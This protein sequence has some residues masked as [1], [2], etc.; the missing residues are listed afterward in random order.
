M[1]WLLRR[2]SYL[3]CRCEFAVAPR[4]YWPYLFS[5]NGDETSHAGQKGTS[6]S[7]VRFLWKADMLLLP[8]GW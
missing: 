2:Y 5:L 4:H 6:E 1:N 7:A 8:Q 3:S